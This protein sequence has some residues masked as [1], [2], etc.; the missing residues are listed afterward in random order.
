LRAAGALD[1]AHRVDLSPLRWV[2]PPE[3]L[4]PLVVSSCAG[5]QPLSR[6]PARELARRCC[7]SASSCR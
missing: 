7:C 6:H 1:H 2:Q 5:S 3:G 4:I